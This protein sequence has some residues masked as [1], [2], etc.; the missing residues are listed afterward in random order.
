[1]I[2]KNNLNSIPEYKEVKVIKSNTHKNT[3]DIDYNIKLVIL[4]RLYMRRT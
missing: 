4:Q 2:I 3:T 1:M